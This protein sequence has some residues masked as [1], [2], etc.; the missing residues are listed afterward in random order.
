VDVIGYVRTLA[1]GPAADTEPGPQE[2]AIHSWA[3]ARGH[4]VIDTAH[5]ELIPDSQGLPRRL[6][7]ARAL[8]A[9]R[10]GVAKAIVVSSLDRLADE[11]VLQEF[12]LADIRACGAEV[13]SVEDDEPD[14]NTTDME[15]MGIRSALSARR[16]YEHSKRELLINH[17]VART[18]M[19]RDRQQAAIALIEALARG[20]ASVDDIGARLRAEGFHSGSGHLFTRPRL[21]RM[22]H[23]RPSAR[24]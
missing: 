12:L 1:W 14:G 20:G 19:P 15:R 10:E 23:R 3:E 21:D 18:R 13:F 5:D 6:A 11:V 16:R 4:R 7:L 9:A 22:L 17:E 2:Q 8:E 24:A